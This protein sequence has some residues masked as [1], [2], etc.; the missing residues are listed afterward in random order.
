MT[1]PARRQMG[2]LLDTTRCIGCNACRVSCQVHNATGPAVAWRLVTSHEQG[3]FPDVTRHHLSIACNHCERPACLAA[4]PEGAI[5]K[6][7]TDGIVLI[8]SDRCNG[9]G[10]CIGACPYGAPQRE[11]ERD[12]VSKCD[13]CVER[14]EKGQPPVCVET[15]VGGALLFGALDELA[16]QAPTRT[17]H[18]TIDGFPDPEWTRPAIRFLIDE[19]RI[20]TDEVP[21]P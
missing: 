5:H 19:P 9:C 10:R 8:D 6:R 18:R 7:E 20:A 15:C 1:V 16:E 2:F 3:S 13:F 11:P 14:Q 17:L 21:R 12:A 4:C